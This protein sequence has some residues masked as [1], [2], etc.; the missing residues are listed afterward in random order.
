MGAETKASVKPLPTADA[1]GEADLDPGLQPPPTLGLPPNHAHVV[2][3][4]RCSWHGPGVD[5]PDCGADGVVELHLDRWINHLS[6][7]LGDKLDDNGVF[8]TDVYNALAPHWTDLK[9]IAC[10]TKANRFY[11]MQCQIC[12]AACIG[13]YGDQ[14]SNGPQTTRQQALQDLLDF[15]KVRQRGRPRV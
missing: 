12:P 11:S 14:N 5:L 9:V 3:P 8:E 10:R 15:C 7:T 13:Y 4:R 1:R 6:A 2:P